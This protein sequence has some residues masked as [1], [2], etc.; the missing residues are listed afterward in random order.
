MHAERILKLLLSASQR[1]TIVRDGFPFQEKL[2]QGARSTKREES[3]EKVLDAIVCGGGF[4]I[5]VRKDSYLP[6]ALSQCLHALYDELSSVYPNLILVQAVTE[7]DD[8][9]VRQ[10]L[11]AG[12]GSIILAR[13]SDYLFF[14]GVSYCNVD[15]LKI[16]LALQKVM[17]FY[18]TWERRRDAVRSQTPIL[19]DDAKHYFAALALV[20][21]NDRVD[22]S[23]F[24]NLRPPRARLDLNQARNMVRSW[25][26]DMAPFGGGGDRLLDVL[27]QQA[28]LSDAA[29]IN[30]VRLAANWYTDLAQKQVKPQL[31]RLGAPLLEE[32]QK[33]KFPKDVLA[34]LLGDNRATLG[35]L[36][37]K[38]SRS[39][40]HSFEPLLQQLWTAAQ[41]HIVSLSP[42][43]R[44]DLS[45][46]GFRIETRTCTPGAGLPIDIT[47]VTEV[48]E[49][50][51]DRDLATLALDNAINSELFDAVQICVL[52]Q[53]ATYASHPSL[54]RGVSCSC[55]EMMR[56]LQPEMPRLSSD[57]LGNFLSFFA[58]WSACVELS[59]MAYQLQRRH[60]G[61]CESLWYLS[62]SWLLW[63]MYFEARE[64]RA[65]RQHGTGRASHPS[66]MSP[67]TGTTTRETSHRVRGE[68]VAAAHPGP[69]GVQN[70]VAAGVTRA[71]G[72]QSWR[73]RP[74]QPRSSPNVRRQWGTWQRGGSRQERQGARYVYPGETARPFS[75]QRRDNA[76]NYNRDR[77][78]SPRAEH[79]AR[80]QG[81]QDGGHAAAG[82]HSRSH[83]YFSRGGGVGLSDQR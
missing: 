19:D 58:L 80:S 38:G 50:S 75:E 21:G 45:G 26:K 41:R 20:W 32:F 69:N 40:Y 44:P 51:E 34:M 71:D 8:E 64:G 9:V 46:H 68:T 56:V 18:V 57:E 39:S 23:T 5:E 61:K 62:D 7:G 53:L 77:A 49:R 79:S 27:C 60:V 28:G 54:P 76:P 30:R 17:F 73:Q 59:T 13:D 1:V 16:D 25:Y 10:A 82:S 3:C 81:R 72:Q 4:S 70:R 14:P 78:R 12:P 65:C 35:P 67:Q 24:E 2:T 74:V 22:A 31:E 63:S 11:Q 33:H 42:D 43:S 47:G 55:K 6:P 29:D 83:G 66:N 52:R 15:K 36:L 48:D 37:E